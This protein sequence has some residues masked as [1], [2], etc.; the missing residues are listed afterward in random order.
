ML[1]VRIV[2]RMNLFV[3]GKLGGARGKGRAGSEDEFLE[4][5]LI[6]HL[7]N[8]GVGVMHFARS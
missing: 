2:R 6:N 3:R 8:M 1:I 5:R 4:K 7:E